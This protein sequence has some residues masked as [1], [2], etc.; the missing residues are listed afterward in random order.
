MVVFRV[1]AFDVKYLS[2]ILHPYNEIDLIN[3]PNKRAIL[4][5]IKGGE[6]QRAF[7][8]STLPSYKSLV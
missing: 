4:R 7:S 5:L 1:G 2:R 3:Q 8:M 6:P